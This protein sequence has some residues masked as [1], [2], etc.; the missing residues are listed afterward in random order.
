MSGDAGA[1]ESQRSITTPFLSKTYLMVDD[2]AV[3]DLISWNEE[4]TAFIVWRPAEFARDLL[5]KYFKH[6]N[7]SSFVRQLNTYGFRKVVPDRWEFANDFFRRDE[8]ELLNEIHRRKLPPALSIPV[9][10]LP[11]RSSASNSA[12]EQAISSN[13]SPT[14]THPPALKL[15]PSSFDILMENDRLKKEN[16][17]LSEELHH[18]RGL[19]GSIYS[20]MSNYATNSA[21]ATS[22]SGDVADA[23]PSTSLNE[24]EQSYPR[25]FGVPIGAK[26]ARRCEPGEME[27][28]SPATPRGGEIK[29]DPLSASR[30]DKYN[31]CLMLIN[32]K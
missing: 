30:T 4:G 3:D 5:P 10:S 29:P 20:L 19:C 27:D 23:Q 22:R 17:R 32:N 15:C 13:S 2:S 6:N 9:A 14:I 16:S 11:N 28:P 7:F 26:R 18:L 8:K 1:G 12:E 31:P 21:A 25:I 24:E